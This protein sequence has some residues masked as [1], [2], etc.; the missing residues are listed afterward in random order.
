MLT[1]GVP[2]FRQKKK[3]S[4]PVWYR[5]GTGWVRSG[6]GRDKTK[7]KR[8]RFRVNLKPYLS[9]PPNS[10][11]LVLF[12]ATRFSLYFALDSL[13]SLLSILSV[14]HFLTPPL[15][16]SVLS[17]SLSHSTGDGRRNGRGGRGDCGSEDLR[18]VGNPRTS[19]IVDLIVVF[20]DFFSH[21]G[22]DC[23]DCGMGLWYFC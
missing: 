18:R 5:S 9:S 14:S 13:S 17:F 23:S 6:T 1:P 11:P 2:V 7:P 16:H 4:V 10:Q 15:V 3:F 21:F 22:S 12:S 19:L 8:R 20:S